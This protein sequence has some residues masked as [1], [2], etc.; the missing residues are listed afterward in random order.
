MLRANALAYGI[1]CGIARVLVISG[2]G[3]VTERLG[4]RVYPPEYGRPFHIPL[5]PVA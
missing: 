2:F 4:R 3:R 5:R 1:A